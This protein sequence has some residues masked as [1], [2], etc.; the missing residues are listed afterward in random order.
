MANLAENVYVALMTADFADLLNARATNYQVFLFCWS[1]FFIK[2]KGHFTNITLAQGSTSFAEQLRS[3]RSYEILFSA[4]ASIENPDQRR[5][6]IETLESM[7]MVSSFR[8]QFFQTAISDSD[9]DENP[10]AGGRA[11]AVTPAP[12]VPVNTVAAA[13]VNP[14]A[15]APVGAA[16]AGADGV[17]EHAIAPVVVKNAAMGDGVGHAAG[18]R[19][20]GREVIV[21]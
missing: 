5:Y 3:L 17:V 18:G 10:A 21:L 2:I 6:A 14:V 9:E 1:E 20:R 16:N 15:L 8:E 12:A 13:L 11:R 4:I 19:K 7:G